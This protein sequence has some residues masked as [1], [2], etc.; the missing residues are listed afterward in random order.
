VL[1]DQFG[2]QIQY[3][4]A[5]SADRSSR[6]RPFEPVQLRDINQLVPSYDRKTLLSASR[7]LYLN[8]GPARGAIDQKAMYSVGR[9]WLPRFRGADAE[10]GRI[11]E[12]WLSG[13]WYGIGDV[14]GGMHDFRTG[15]YLLSVAIDRDGEAFVLL[16]ES[17]DGYPRYQ[18]IPAH[19]I[20]NPDGQN[21]GPYNGQMLIDGILYNR[22][23]APIAYS[24]LDSQGNFERFIRAFDIIHIYD[25]S[26]QEQGRGLPAFTHALNDLRDMLQ[27]HE[28][29]RMAQ[30]ML[31][32][33]G[34]IET[35]E[36][37]MPDMDDPA[38]ALLGN[39]GDIGAQ[40]TVSKL[41]GGSIRYIRA[42]SGAKIETISNDRPGS[43]WT[44]F[45]DRIIRS[46]LSGINWSYS[47]V[48][49]G[50]Q[51]GGGTA[52]RTEIAM[53]QRAV[54]D[55]QDVLLYAAKRLIGYAVAKAQK[56]NI[57]PE[58]SDWYKWEFTYPS[59]LTIDDGRVAKELESQWKSGFRNQEEIVGMFG[60]SLEEHLE[61]RAR[62]VALRKLAAKRASEIYGVPVDDREMAMMTA[63]EQP[64]QDPQNETTDD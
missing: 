64:N 25:P 16:T 62:E 26:W 15:L 7:R 24:Y 9:A 4:A 51:I 6:S 8:L 45:H 63:N 21:D 48:W 3:Q 14:R 20:G 46:A 61:Q 17:K 2:Y 49:K 34:I 39:T 54:E 56:N 37:G 19:R 10:F 11:A 38:N 28:W 27:S 41:D 22:Q 55:R 35:N 12:E 43:A 40:P 31:S 33:I 23:G 32:S 42:G 18:H 13:Q 53:A 58:S 1:V 44:D 29:E 57:I 50:N 30:L 60:R 47:L 36:H 52:Q 59:K 5:R